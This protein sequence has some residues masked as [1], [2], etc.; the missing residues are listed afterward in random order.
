MKQV[1]VRRGNIQ[2]DDVPAPLLADN[3]IL[4]EVAYSLIS[5]G[6]EVTAVKRSGESL[7]KKAIHQPENVKKVLSIL[8]EKGI[9]K[10]LALV[11]SK[12]GG[13]SPTGYSCSGIV[14]QVGKGVEG[15]K[16]GDQVACAGAGKANHAEIVLIPKNLVTKIPDGCDLQDAASVTLGSIAM[17]GVRRADPKLGETVAVVGLGLV[18]QIT[19]QLLKIAGCR[20]IGFDIQRSRVELA[21]ELGLDWGFVSSEVDIQKEVLNLTGGRGVDTTIITA[22]AP[23]NDTI[24][25]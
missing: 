18:G 22:S 10:T 9:K 3:H 5:T 23:D 19:N 6:T 14:I 1:L 25:Q 2:I 16:P 8:K 12:V 11:K 4:V 21:K 17:Q 24:V 15:I 7:A 13:A 20:T